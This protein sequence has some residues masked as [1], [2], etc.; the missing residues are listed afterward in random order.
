MEFIDGRDLYVLRRLRERGQVLPIEAAAFIAMEACGLQ[1]AH[2]KKDVDGRPLKIV[3]RDI[4]PQNVVVSF[5]GEVK[6]IDFGIAKA[7]LRAYET[8]AGVI[9][10]KF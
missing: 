10:G 7:E 2:D 4:S 3:H 9:K 1:Y 5:E 8:E 6:L